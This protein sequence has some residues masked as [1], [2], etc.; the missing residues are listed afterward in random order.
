M[1]TLFLPSVDGPDE[2]PFVE[3]ERRL[4]MPLGEHE[5]NLAPEVVA[6][7]ARGAPGQ[8]RDEAERI[9]NSIKG[10]LARLRDIDGGA[11]GVIGDPGDIFG[12]GRGGPDLGGGP[13]SDG[14][15]TG[16]PDPGRVSDRIH[17]ID[18]PL[19][20]ASGAE[21]EAAAMRRAAARQAMDER[22]ALIERNQDAQAMLDLLKDT[23]GDSEECQEQDDWQNR[24]AQYWRLR[25]E[26]RNNN[27]RID[28]LTR[29]IRDSSG[30]IRYDNPDGDSGGSRQ[31]SGSDWLALY[32]KIESLGGLVAP[33]DREAAGLG[34]QRPKIFGAVDPGPD[35]DEG[36]SSLST[37]TIW[38]K[39]LID[40]KPER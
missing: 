21:E 4:E 36:S 32:A 18:D 16:G 25:D 1:Q 29:F 40:P 26:I 11:G 8:L 10:F 7:L 15:G 6:A 2:V 13:G 27:I 22:K 30:S 33:S 35:S 39:N 19:G 5:F 37:V 38:L 23:C 9:Q 17:R 31:P 20:R 3:R 24:R 34:S 28:S 14:L 12:F